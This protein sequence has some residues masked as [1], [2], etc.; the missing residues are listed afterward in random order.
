MSRWRARVSSIRAT[1]RG[2]IRT[3]SLPVAGFA[4]SCGTDANTYRRDRP[5]MSAFVREGG[6]V[7][8]TYSTYARGLDA[9]W[10]AYQWLDRAPLGRNE[11]G[12]WWKR[13]DEYGGR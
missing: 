5:G 3:G 10:G 9:L 8:H 7:Y 12:P 1:D 11:K 4:A 6:A 13:R 2:S